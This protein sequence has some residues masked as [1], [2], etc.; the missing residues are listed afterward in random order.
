MDID[1]YTTGDTLLWHGND[2]RGAARGATNQS[3]SAARIGAKLQTH[4]RP[5]YSKRPY[6]MQTRVFMIYTA[7]IQR[8]ENAALYNQ[9]NDS[10]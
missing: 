6:V 8:K 5:V 7:H 9:T 3:C 10:A 1:I 2:R 4:H